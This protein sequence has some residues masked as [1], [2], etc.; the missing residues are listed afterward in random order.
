MTVAKNRRK[1]THCSN[2]SLWLTYK[3]IAYLPLLSACLCLRAIKASAI[4]HITI[5][6]FE[7]GHAVGE[8]VAANKKKSAA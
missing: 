3:Q 5:I 6:A 1:T 4:S 2:N 7:T 8:I